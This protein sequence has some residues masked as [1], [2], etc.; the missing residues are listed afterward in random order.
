MEPERAP[1]WEHWLSD[2]FLEFLATFVFFSSARHAS[3][4]MPSQIQSR[5]KMKI[6]RYSSMSQK[7]INAVSVLWGKLI[8]CRTS[9]ELHSMPDTFVALTA[10]LEHK[11][12]PTKIVSTVRLLQVEKAKRELAE[13]QLVAARRSGARGAKARQILI[14]KE[15]AV[16]EAEKK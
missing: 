3:A 8:V 14:A 1:C 9:F 10:A 11:T 2:E 16:E 13:A 6:S 12:E 15:N 4:P 7:A 5:Q